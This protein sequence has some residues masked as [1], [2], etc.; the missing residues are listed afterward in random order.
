MP[1]K[2]PQISHIVTIQFT[3][4]LKKLQ[5]PYKAGGAQLSLLNISSV[6]KFLDNHDLIYTFKLANMAADQ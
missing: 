5:F 3:M 2:R 4:P 1:T 6:R